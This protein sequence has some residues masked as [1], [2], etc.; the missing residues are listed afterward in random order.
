MTAAADKLEHVAATFCGICKGPCTETRKRECYAFFALE[1]Y[2][3][4]HEGTDEIFD[5]PEPKL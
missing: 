5:L 1:I 4:E 3:A 2:R